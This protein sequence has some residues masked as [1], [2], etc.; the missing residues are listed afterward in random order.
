MYHSGNCYDYSK[1]SYNFANLHARV[2]TF[3]DGQDSNLPTPQYTD[4]SN[5]PTNQ[6]RNGSVGRISP[7]T[8]PP[9]IHS[10]RG[11]ELMRHPRPSAYSITGFSGYPPGHPW[12]IS[13]EPIIERPP[14]PL[15]SS[16]TLADEQR[17]FFGDLSRELRLQMH[18]RSR[19]LE[20]FITRDSLV[21]IWSVARLCKLIELVSPGFDHT[22]ITHIRDEYVQTLSILVDISWQ[23][24]QRFGEVFLQHPGR[25]DRMIPRY[26]LQTLDD[27][28]FLDTPWADKFL[29]HRYIFCPINIR[30]GRSLAL[31]NGWRLPFVNEESEPIGHGGYGQVTREVVGSGHFHSQS[32]HHLQGAPYSKDI[33]VAVKRFAA[34]RDFGS[35]TKNLDLLR[36]SLSQH[37]RI[38][39]FLA[40]ISIGKDFNILSPLA[41]MNLEEFLL[42]GHRRV[43]GITVSELIK[44]AANLAGALAFLHT[45]LDSNPPGL[46]CCHMDLK[47]SNIL[48]FLGT[49]PELKVGK[50]KI[51]DFGI[52]IFQT[53]ERADQ[54]ATTVTEFVDTLTQRQE[55]RL[56]MGP[57]Q[58][59][60]GGA[61]PLSD[62]W[63]LGCILTRILAFGLGGVDEM[64]RL[65]QLRSTEHDGISPYVDD[66]FHRGAPAELNPHIKNWL[67]DLPC[68]YEY[69]AS[70]LNECKS[71]VASM[72]ALK[73]DDRPPA[74]A[75]KARLLSLEHQPPEHHPSIPVTSVISPGL[76]PVVRRSHQPYARAIYLIQAIEDAHHQIL[77]DWLNMGADVEERD[78]RGVRPLI[79]AVRC[80]NIDAIRLLLSYRPS[81]DLETPDSKGDTPLKIAAGDSRCTQLVELLLNAGA[82]IDAPS[83]RGLTPL[84]IAC[85][86]GLTETVQV[87][88]DR[89]ANTWLSADN[90]YTCLHYA[91]H[92][93]AQA[94]IIQIL[95]GR[96]PSFD[97]PRV[98][99]GETPLLTLVKNFA[100]TTSWRTGFKALLAMGADINQPDA[101]LVT[102]LSW[103][104][105]EKEWTLVEVLLESGAVPENVQRRSDM[106]KKIQKMMQ[107]AE[108]PETDI[109]DRRASSGSSG[110]S[111]RSIIRRMSS[112]FSKGRLSSGL[113]GLNG[114][115]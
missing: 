40:T 86:H 82:S 88:L 30:E 67:T 74:K 51:S 43:S 23:E 14:N 64:K 29:E 89:G 47:P 113:S 68:H 87:L 73:R 39:P 3:S 71:I 96:V 11:P 80:G 69:N 26:T 107:K 59:P 17:E 34:Q 75:V 28:S 8:V 97:T 112:T 93:N 79:Q 110:S 54:T 108:R 65:D 9:P 114:V 45:G 21:K 46:E 83:H 101:N 115:R 33:A 103:A 38:V 106:P 16:R 58:P 1:D 77:E 15:R 61:S 109:G 55:P 91:M 6:D 5:S 41:D 63:S 90:G 104:I 84:M 52:S 48:V 53:R 56:A 94:E 85:R 60:D 95:A 76:D 22:F 18:R 19:P 42:E 12:T 66:Y 4:S 99:G 31:P 50:W 100:S 44:E 102:P 7:R 35:E 20:K 25:S 49:A 62:V 98:Y 27:P 24:W 57:Y 111:A 72:L 92:S 10:P 36:K 32:E 13:P 105:K 2:A 70:F 78:E 37:D 81:L